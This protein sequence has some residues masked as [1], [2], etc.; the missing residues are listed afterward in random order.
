[1]NTNFDEID[2][3]ESGVIDKQKQLR[4]ISA[5]RND[6]VVPERKFKRVKF[7]KYFDRKLFNMKLEMEA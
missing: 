5:L 4:K 2:A 1:M 6:E 7:P 3:K